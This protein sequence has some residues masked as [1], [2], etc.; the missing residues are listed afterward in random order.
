MKSIRF[1]DR[2]EL[3]NSRDIISF[4]Q[5][6]IGKP[7]VKGCEVFVGTHSITP[8]DHLNCEVKINFQLIKGKGK[9]RKNTL[10]VFINKRAVDFCCQSMTHYERFE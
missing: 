5:Y 1:N 8:V 10:Y 4:M 6:L 7:E 9:N 2:S 3:L